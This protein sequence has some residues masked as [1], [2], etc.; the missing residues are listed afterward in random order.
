[1][2]I[3][4]EQVTGNASPGLLDVL[5]LERIEADMFRSSVVYDDPFGLY[6]GQVA[7]QALL[8]AA[9]TVPEGRYPHSLH[10]YFL[11]RGDPARRVLLMVNRDRD[12][13]SYSNRRVIAVQDGVVIF[14]MAASF[15]VIEDGP[16]YQA[17]TMPPAAPPDDLPGLS[18]RIRMLGIETRVPVQPVPGQEWP[19]R[20]WM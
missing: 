4:Q 6:G 3:R 7:A 11:S 18:G 13:R 9:Q 19:S 20:V 14:N 12:G 2:S 10:G 1:M 15:E 17:H 8:A 16:D 5:T